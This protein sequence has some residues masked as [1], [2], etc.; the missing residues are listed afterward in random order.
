MMVA[1]AYPLA[2][3]ITNALSEVNTDRRRPSRVLAVLFE[4]SLR[5]S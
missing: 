4:A 1:V 5:R 2:A 3:P